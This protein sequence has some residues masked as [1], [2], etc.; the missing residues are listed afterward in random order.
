MTRAE[1][2]PNIGP[3][4][5]GITWSRLL[6]ALLFGFAGL[7]HFVVPAPYVAI[8]PP[9]LPAPRLLV[10]ISGVFE[11]LGGLGILVPRTRRFAGW[12]LIALLVAVF[13]ANIQMLRLAYL[14]NATLLWKVGLWLRLPLQPLVIWWVWRAAARARR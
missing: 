13:P 7:M 12:G 1:E 9:W 5:Y 11:I 6:L 3:S 8:V 14:A 2:T 4:S 10:A